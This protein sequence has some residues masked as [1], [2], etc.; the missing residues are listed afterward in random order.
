MKDSFG[1]KV[2]KLA[3]EESG[4]AKEFIAAAEVK[5]ARTEVRFDRPGNR[6]ETTTVEVFI[7]YQGTTDYVVANITMIT[8]FLVVSVSRIR[9]DAHRN[10]IIDTEET[11]DVVPMDDSIATSGYEIAGNAIADQYRHAEP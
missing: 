9:R 4:M 5:V 3:L 2:V 10:N 6:A 11:Y 1:A 8:N 7:P